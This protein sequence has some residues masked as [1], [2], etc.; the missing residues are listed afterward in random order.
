MPLNQQASE[1]LRL[2][3]ARGDAPVEEST[4]AEA[5]AGNWSWLEFMGE[6]EAVHRVMDTY[7]PGPTA[8][9]HVRVYTPTGPGP[10]PGLVFFHGGGWT[11]GNIEILDRPNRRLANAT[12]CV[13]VAVNYQKAPE[14]PFPTALDDCFATVRWVLEHADALDVDPKRLGVAG[15]S[16]GG[17]LAAAVCLKARERTDVPLAFQV[18]IYPALDPEL[19]APSARDRAE[20]YGLTTAAMRWFWN[21]YLPDA[22]QRD[23]PLA[24]PLLATSLRNLPPAIIVTAGYDPLRDDGERYAD[25][26]QDAGVITFRHSYASTI[27][28]FYCMGDALNEDFGRLLGDLAHDLSSLSLTP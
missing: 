7:V 1:M 9:L 18:L 4:V 24:A 27:H 22:T 6:A 3:E 8:E 21:N 26:L 10:F 15:D 28:G 19:D 13:V 25:R 2:V 17:N 20:G 16:A 14:H 11:V 12:G 23:N 5:R